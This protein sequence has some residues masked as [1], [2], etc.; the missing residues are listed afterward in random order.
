MRVKLS[1]TADVEEIYSEATLLLGSLNKT[2]QSVVNNYNN[3]L[4]ELQGTE[5]N[6]LKI[7]KNISETRQLLEKIDRR[8][9]EVGDILSGYQEYALR[10]RE[11]LFSEE[12]FPETTPLIDEGE[13]DD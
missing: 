5:P 11:D 4:Q 3:V 2:I 1:Y 7:Q 8:S 10:G 13:K 9:A 6:L 12:D